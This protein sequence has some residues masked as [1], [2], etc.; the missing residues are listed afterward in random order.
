M[1]YK[2]LEKIYGEFDKYEGPLG[3]IY[4]KEQTKFILWAPLAESVDVNLYGKDGKCVKGRCIK[5]VPMK[6]NDDGT[7]EALIKGDLNGEIYNYSVNND[8]ILNDVVDPYAKAVTVNGLRGIVIDL[9]STDPIGFEKDVK[10]QLI[11]A[12]D[13]ILYEMH[14]R[15]FTID[16]SSGVKDEL[17][18][19]YLGACKK[20][21]VIP[22]TNTS[23]CLDY[24]KN[25]GVTHV[26]LLPIEDYETVDE[27]KCPLEEYN[28]GYDP[29]NYNVPEGSY[30]TAV[31]DGATRIREVKEMVKSFH[32]NGIRVVMDVVYNH[33]YKTEDS[34][35]NKAVP[36]YYYRENNDGSFSNGSAC[37]NEIA[38]DRKMV[39]KL[40]VDSVVYWAK[41]YHIDGFRFDLMG[42]T[43]IDTLK[44]IRTE[45]DKI[46]KT[47]IMYGEGWTGGPSPLPIEKSAIKKNTIK[48]DKMQIASFSDD[49]RDGIK[50]HVFDVNE[51]GFASGKSGLEETIKM[52][53]V[54][55][56][57]HKDIDYSKVVYSDSNWAN[58]PYQTINYVSA[59]DNNTLWD[60]LQISCPELAEE[61]RKSINKLCAA[62]VLT[63]QG[64]PFFQ[65]GEEFL[66]TKIDENGQLIENS[67]NLPDLVNKMDWNRMAQNNDTVDYYKGLIALRKSHKAFR[68]DNA[69][70]IRESITFLKQGIDYNYDNVVAYTIDCSSI[71]DDFKEI[72][73]VYNGGSDSI[74]LPIKEGDWMVYVDG[75]KASDR[76]IGRFIGSSIIVNKRS[77]L[78][79]AR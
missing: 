40:I 59:H 33:T 16:K 53:A 1:E 34:N 31:D 23:T 2:A 19:K 42:L 35:L 79:L 32:E 8:G 73:V 67:Y 18:G 5:K 64:I 48:F 39:R 14:I 38:S 20:N 26:H 54:G 37:G 72:L 71:D 7:W 51:K 11:N 30:S 24:I 44:E 47:I 46:D 9:K 29:Q 70:D 55:A 28:W 69:D 15:D 66:R 49:C 21:T 3:A 41:E 75:E 60:K 27:S 52:T 76:P 56:I 17:R 62:I 6:S 74:Q 50:G 4:D 78:V 36:Y 22:N 65:A 61:D 13:S 43:D 57:N 63:S 10:P 45:L 58:E 77:C 25:L 12:T 68:L